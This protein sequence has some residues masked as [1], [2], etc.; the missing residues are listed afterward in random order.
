MGAT[1]A[2]R[3]RADE[4]TKT[5]VRALSKSA[6]VASTAAARRAEELLSLI[7]RRIKRISEDFF[8]IGLA[9]QEL[10]KKKLFVALGYASFAAMMAGRRIMS[11]RAADKLID[12]VAAVK[13]D[14]A[15]V[16]GQEKA[17]ALA[18][19]VAATPEPDT[20]ADVVAEGA[21]VRGKKVAVKDLTTREI[22]AVA[23]KARPTRATPAA[24]EAKAA[25]RTLQAAARAAGAKHAV[26]EVERRKG[27]AWARLEAPAAE[28]ESLL[29][30]R[31]A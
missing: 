2:K 4:R 19:L 11:A 12:I 15:L 13:R 31:R 5:N 17:Y 7:T 14:Q 1:M 10:K 25:A 6:V 30:R 22:A 24:A 20:V 27:K 18:R 9:L 28:L 29:A 8:E 23:K 26:V 3:T 21:T 16:L